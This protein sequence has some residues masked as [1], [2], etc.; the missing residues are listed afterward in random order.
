MLSDARRRISRIAREQLLDRR[1][2]HLQ[3]AQ[4]HDK[5]CVVE[6]G[7]VV[8]AITGRLIDAR[9][10]QYPAFVVEA[11]CLQRQAGPSCELPD[12]DLFHTD[13]LVA[14]PLRPGKGECAGSPKVRVKRLIQRP[15]GQG[16]LATVSRTAESSSAWRL[17][18]AAGTTS[19]SPGRPSQECWPPPA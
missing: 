5:A 12:A 13:S 3:L 14:G 18:G 8:V 7:C 2:R 9:R 11:Q 10:H 4:H 15:R 17:C 1:E 16:S 6:L 19:R